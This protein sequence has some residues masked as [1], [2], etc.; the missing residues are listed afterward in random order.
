MSINIYNYYLFNNYIMTKLTKTQKEQ[1]N[2]LLPVFCLK[3]QP[4]NNRVLCKHIGN[5][6]NCEKLCDIPLDIETS[7]ELCSQI[8]KNT[9]LLASVPNYLIVGKL[10]S[11]NIIGNYLIKNDKL[12]V[13]YLSA[14]YSKKFVT[15]CLFNLFLYFT[16]SNDT[17]QELTHP[18]KYINRSM[19]G[20][21]T[22]ELVPLDDISKEEK[23]QD[24]KNSNFLNKIKKYL[25]ID[26][27]KKNL[28]DFE[29]LGE[30]E[31]VKFVENMTNEINNKMEQYK[32]L[33]QPINFTTYPKK[34]T[35]IEEMKKIYSNKLFEELVIYSLKIREFERIE[36]KCPDISYD[37]P[38]NI[39]N[40]KEIHKQPD[41]LDELL[42]HEK[43]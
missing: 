31:Q 37:I 3:P 14:I 7:D 36:E 35:V 9:L 38:K 12:P 5:I 4:G 33:L 6:D 30:E 25:E 28:G 21:Y 13:Y 34:E 8:G 17:K 26:T 29:I 10:C 20:S 24:L 23:P 43:N 11:C 2:K 39:I 16:I 32:E 42:M 18:N 40:L 19:E 1:L 15:G 22:L 41:K 27:F